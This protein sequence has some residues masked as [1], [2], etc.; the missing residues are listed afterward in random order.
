MNKK[1]KETEK[2]IYRRR[3]PNVY[4]VSTDICVYDDYDVH[5]HCTYKRGP[6]FRMIVVRAHCAVYCT[7]ICARI[8]TYTTYSFYIRF[9][10]PIALFRVYYCGGVVYIYAKWNRPRDHR[11]RYRGP[12]QRSRKIIICKKGFFPYTH[13]HSYTHKCEHASLLLVQKRIK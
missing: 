8:Y 10:S 5:I 9:L 1:K 7:C 4:L 2:D 11:D 13:S 6:I 12:W 3:A